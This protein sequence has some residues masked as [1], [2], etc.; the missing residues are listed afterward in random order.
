MP[1]QSRTTAGP[2][3]SSRADSTLGYRQPLA[4]TVHAWQLPP[5]QM[6]R[7]GHWLELVQATQALSTQM[8]VGLAQAA[9]GLPDDEGGWAQDP[10]PS[11]T[12]PGQQRLRFLLGVWPALA[13]SFFFFF[14]FLRSSWTCSPRSSR[15]CPRW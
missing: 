14:L 1:A 7:A 10:L 12:S 13:H 4:Q 11:L 15:R 3:G 8:G 5:S 2:A 9:Q 6:V